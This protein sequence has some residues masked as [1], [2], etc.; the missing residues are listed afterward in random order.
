MRVR[1]NFELYHRLAFIR[2]V[3]FEHITTTKKSQHFLFN[4]KMCQQA[5][6]H[7]EVYCNEPSSYSYLPEVPLRNYRRTMK[8][9]LP[10]KI[11][12][13]A[14]INLNRFWNELEEFYNRY[15]DRRAKNN[16]NPII[17]LQEQQSTTKL[18]LPA[19]TTDTFDHERE[20]AENLLNEHL[21]ER[22]DIGT[23]I[24][25]GGQHC[26]DCCCCYTNPP[27]YTSI[28]ATSL[29]RDRNHSC[30]IESESSSHNDSLSDAEEY[31]DSDDDLFF[32]TSSTNN[33]HQKQAYWSSSN[34]TT[35]PTTPRPPRTLLDLIHH[36]GRK[37]Y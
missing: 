11:S 18:K 13:P 20:S 28:N 17:N 31:S 1:V 22:S 6:S 24:V 33:G 12:A 8:P 5:T 36:I 15:D 2:I 26:C 37:E 21:E 9:R 10:R 23:K 14:R 29:F 7:G 34:A 4:N 19:Y 35:L 3:A 30:G 27:L 25:S 16:N 32:R